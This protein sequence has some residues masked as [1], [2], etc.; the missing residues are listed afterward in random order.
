MNAS[1]MFRRHD[2]FDAAVGC[3][4]DRK[5]VPEY[6]GPPVTGRDSALVG[7]LGFGI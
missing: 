4:L 1:A 6:P 7:L 2:G 3:G 5:A